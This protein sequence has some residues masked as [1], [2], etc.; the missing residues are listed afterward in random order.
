[1]ARL[2]ELEREREVEQRRKE[3]WEQEIHRQHQFDLNMARDEE[4]RILEQ[5]HRDE[6]A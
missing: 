4:R 3:Q 2:Q 5:R 1:M 6:I